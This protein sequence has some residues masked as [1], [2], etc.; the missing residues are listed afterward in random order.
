MPQECIEGKDILLVLL[1]HMVTL[2]VIVARLLFAQPNVQVGLS[3]EELGSLLASF[4]VDQASQIAIGR[5]FNAIFE[6]LEWDVLNWNP[7]TAMGVD[8]L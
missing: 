1:E 7:A 5:A 2:Y 3:P 4:L 6:A 8:S